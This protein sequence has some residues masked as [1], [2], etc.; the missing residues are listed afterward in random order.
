[1]KYL[2]GVG[3][4]IAFICVSIAP[5]SNLYDVPEGT[6][7]IGVHKEHQGATA[8]LNH[9]RVC[10]SAGKEEEQARTLDLPITSFTTITRDRHQA[11][12]MKVA[13]RVVRVHKRHRD[14][15]T[16]GQVLKAEH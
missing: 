14:G 3:E 6:L 7:V 10:L 9:S 13:G 11:V 16:K 12:V 5:H 2:F 15:R 8:L 1:M 4:V